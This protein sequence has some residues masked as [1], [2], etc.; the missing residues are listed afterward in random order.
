MANT[1]QAIKC[2]AYFYPAAEVNKEKGLFTI[3]GKEVEGYRIES[4]EK[5]NIMV[6]WDLPDSAAEM[7]KAL[8]KLS[9]KNDDIEYDDFECESDDYEVLSFYMNGK[10]LDED[11]Y[12]SVDFDGDGYLELEYFEVNSNLESVKFFYENES[13]VVVLYSDY[14]QHKDFMTEITSLCR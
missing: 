5:S 12:E 10:E 11:D 3:D 13:E 9:W 1:L 7:I 4:S 6:S 14:S 2:E 8:E